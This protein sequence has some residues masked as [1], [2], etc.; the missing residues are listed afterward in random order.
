MS[1]RNDKNLL[2]DGLN[3]KMNDAK[4]LELDSGCVEYTEK[5]AVCQEK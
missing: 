5:G 3:M 1:R 4:L 2:Q